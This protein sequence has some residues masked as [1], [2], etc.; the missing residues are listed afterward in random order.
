MFVGITNAQ[1]T[2]PWKKRLKMAQDF[3]KEGDYYQAAVYYEGIY[4]EKSDKPEF[5]Y[6][7]GNCIMLCEI[8]RIPLRH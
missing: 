2:L 5:T 7:A 8:M 6:K 3:Q 4:A 1:K